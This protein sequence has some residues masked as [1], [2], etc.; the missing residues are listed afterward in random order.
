MNV[1]LCNFFLSAIGLAAIL[2]SAGRAS[3]A[4][5]AITEWMYNSSST[6]GEYV[7]FTNVTKAP[8]DM[9]NWSEDD[10]NRT[11]GKHA[12]GSTFGIVQPGQSV[13]LTESTPAAFAAAWHLSNSVKIIGPYSNDNLGRSDEINLYDNHGVLVDRLT[14][15]DQGTNGGP[16][17]SGFGGNIPLANLGQNTPQ[18]AV[19]SAVGD[20]YGSFASTNGDVGNPGAYTA[21]QVPEPSTVTL[22]AVGGLVLAG[23]RLARRR[24]VRA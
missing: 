8:I 15:N 19:L 6:G 12:F 21:F 20:S 17:T 2:A 1:R 13:I 23:S 9:T 4:S 7:E 5:M 11:A 10:N 24:K 22:V 14:F 16:R 3:A 18:H